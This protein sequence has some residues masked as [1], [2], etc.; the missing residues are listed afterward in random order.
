VLRAD[1][2]RDGDHSPVT[3]LELDG[4]RVTR[5]EVWPG[6]QLYGLPVLL[7]AARSAS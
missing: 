4:G 6:P 5:T 2:P 3:L 1:V 7:P